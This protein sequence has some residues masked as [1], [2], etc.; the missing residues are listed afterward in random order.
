[1]AIKRVSYVKHATVNKKGILEMRVKF[2]D[3]TVGTMLK[4]IPQP[5]ELV[6]PK[7]DPDYHDLYEFVR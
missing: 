3:K 6:K 7:V 4:I 2:Q 1:M 5:D